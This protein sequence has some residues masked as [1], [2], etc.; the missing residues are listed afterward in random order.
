VGQAH[1]LSKPIIIALGVVKKQAAL[2][3]WESPLAPH[4]DDRSPEIALRKKQCVA[5]N[6]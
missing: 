6:S 2:L 5:E 3:S 4:P 1:F